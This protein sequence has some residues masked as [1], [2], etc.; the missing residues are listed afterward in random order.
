MAGRQPARQPAARKTGPA[1]WAAA[2]AGLAGGPGAQ[3]LVGGGE[4]GRRRHGRRRHGRRPPPFARRA[5]ARSM[6]RRWTTRPKRSWTSG[7]RLGRPQR[8]V[9][10]ALLLEEGHHGG[11]ELV[12]AAGTGPDR[13]QAGQTRR[14]PGRLGG[15]EGRPGEAE[16]GGGLGDRLA[17]GQHAAQ[18]LVLDLDQVAGVE[19]GV[20]A[21]EGRVDHRLGAGVEGAR[22]AQGGQFVIWGSH[23]HLL[24]GYDRMIMP[25]SLRS[26]STSSCRNVRSIRSTDTCTVG[27]PIHGA[28]NAGK[29]HNLPYEAA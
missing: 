21:G 24:R 6:L 18:H 23:R 2:R 27:S 20:A 25:N 9:A 10:G 28:G 8:G 12:A 17:V 1:R 14:L 7:T 3:V 15:V 19:E 16:G 13:Q 29:R 11:G 4:G 26:L 22:G 5:S